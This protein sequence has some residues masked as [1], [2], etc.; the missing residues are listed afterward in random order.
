MINVDISDTGIGIST[1]NGA[2]RLADELKDIRETC[3]AL[4]PGGVYVIDDGSTQRDLPLT[5][6]VCEEFGVSLG[7]HRRNQGISATWNHLVDHF[8]TKKV[9][10]ILNDDLRLVPNWL[11]SLVFFADN[12]PT[13]SLVGLH[14][15]V[16]GKVTCTDAGV[17]K[18]DT[19]IDFSV[20]HR[21]LCPNGFC[22]V[23]RP[24]DWA[25]VDHFDEY[26]YSF[27]EEVDLGVRVFQKSGK[28][29][30]NIPWPV[31]DHLWG[32]TFF[33]NKVDLMPQLRMKMSEK[34]FKEK[35]GGLVADVY[36]KTI[37]TLPPVSMTWLVGMEPKT[38]SCINVVR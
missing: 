27:F 20:P 1:L 23:I 34:R 24:Q 25:S 36:S 10:A 5:R 15:R 26:F 6:A 16:D 35:H 38:G 9:V 32:Q 28:A 18:L 8:K 17:K 3:P 4:F 22:F 11:E 33:E 13:A 14:A 7:E 31:I 21:G 29:C 12:N 37:A 19:E 30:Y 2:A